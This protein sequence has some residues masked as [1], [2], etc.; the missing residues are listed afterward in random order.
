MKQLLKN[1]NTINYRGPDNTS[2]MKIN[3]VLLGHNRLSVI[4]LEQNSN[5]PMTSSCGRY[6]IIFNGEIYNYL[7]LKKQIKNYVLKLILILKLS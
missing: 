2:I 6:V 5:Q 1:L 4:D 3:N 7:D